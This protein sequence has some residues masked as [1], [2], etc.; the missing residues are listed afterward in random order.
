[1]DLCE[2]KV[3]Q[4][5]IGRPSSKTKT[6]E[7]TSKPL[8]IIFDSFSFIW[9]LFSWSWFS[10]WNMYCSV[11]CQHVKVVCVSVFTVHVFVG[12]R[13][14]VKPF[15]LCS[16]VVLFVFESGNR[17][18]SD[19]SRDAC[20]HRCY[21]PLWLCSTLKGP[22]YP[23][24]SVILDTLMLFIPFDYKIKWWCLCHLMKNIIFIF[25]LYF[26]HACHSTYRAQTTFGLFSFLL[27]CSPLG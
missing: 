27:S 20:E 13:Y 16:I 4:D 17:L 7:W 18:G 11:K 24:L 25:L 6:R 2:L 8:K 14:I 26:S 19:L 12:A 5:Y 23:C 3:S 15:Y 9:W 1:M 22:C 21:C 10:L